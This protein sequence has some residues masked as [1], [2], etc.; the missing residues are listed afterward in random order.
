MTTAAARNKER[1]GNL[2]ERDCPSRGV[3]D[4][5]TSRWGSLI[6]VVLCERTHRFSELVRR[7]GGVSEKMLAQSLQVL[8]AD[9]FVTRTVFP[10]NPPKVEYSLTQLG[11]DVATHV[12]ALTGWIEANLSTVMKARASRAFESQASK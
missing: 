2:Y 5:V 10:T 11:R 6:L 4:H 12:H 3:L 1:K 7:I 9:G 8:E